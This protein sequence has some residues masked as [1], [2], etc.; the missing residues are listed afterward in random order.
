MENISKQRKVWGCIA[1]VV[2]GTATGRKNVGV[3]I[4]KKTLRWKVKKTRTMTKEEEE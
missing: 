2:T 4:H 3:L 1:T